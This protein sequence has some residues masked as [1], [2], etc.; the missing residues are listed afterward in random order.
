MIINEL[1]FIKNFG[2]I[3]S[4]DFSY[5][6]D[7]LVE[8]ARNE[9]SRINWFFLSKDHQLNA[10][11]MYILAANKYRVAGE[12]QEAANAMKDAAYIY[13]QKKN[14]YEAGNL[15]YNAGKLTRDVRF[16]C[17]AIP[18]FI[19]SGTEDMTRIYFEIAEMM[20]Y[21]KMFDRALKMYSR[22]AIAAENKEDFCKAGDCYS[23]RASILWEHS[24]Y[25]ECVQEYNLARIAYSKESILLSVSPAFK[26][27]L[28]QLV[29]DSPK[30]VQE[31]LFEYAD[32]FVH[33]PYK[34]NLIRVLID[35]LHDNNLTELDLVIK[36]Y[37]KSYNPDNIEIH[38]LLTI[39]T[40]TDI[41]LS[42]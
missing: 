32:L 27:L 9:K 33:D 37:V 10:A 41:D 29:Y 8:K 23:K 2:K 22:S 4:E 17:L 14:L 6:A 16:F 26:S 15:L 18:Y 7:L 25:P 1:I 40:K 3:M 38:M 28:C 12:Y 35:I 13:A 42:N 30:N 24:K 36:D 11:E 21:S 34:L 5:E 20:K 39:V 19:E 31:K